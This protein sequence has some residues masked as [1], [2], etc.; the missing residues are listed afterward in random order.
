MGALGVVLTQVLALKRL[1]NRQIDAG[2]RQ[3]AQEVGNIASEKHSDALAKKSQVHKYAKILHFVPYP[4]N[5]LYHLTMY[6]IRVTLNTAS[7]SL[8]FV[9]V[10]N[11]VGPD[12]CVF[13]A[14]TGVD[15][16]LIALAFFSHSS[17]EIDT[18]S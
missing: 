8:Q 16:K 12:S 10:N 1:V 14:V 5:Y 7:H 18:F 15:F 3:N 2:I 11:L 9:K 13:G 4:R 6:I 17:F